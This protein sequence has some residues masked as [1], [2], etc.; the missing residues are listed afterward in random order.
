MSHDEL[1]RIDELLAAQDIYYHVSDEVFYGG[2][3]Q[4]KPDEVLA[5]LPGMSLDQ[6]ARYTLGKYDAAIPELWE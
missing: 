4:L 2:K 5:V 3:R 1:H 6:L